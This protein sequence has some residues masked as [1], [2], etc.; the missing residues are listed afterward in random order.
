MR[1]AWVSLSEVAERTEGQ[2]M[3]GNSGLPTGFDQESLQ[4]NTKPLQKA[5]IRWGGYET[6]L[7][8]SFA[9]D[10]DE[11]SVGYAGADGQGTAYAAGAAVKRA[12]TS[13][14]LGET[15]SLKDYYNIRNGQLTVQ[16]NINALN[17]RIEPADQYSPRVR[18]RQI[19]GIVR[20]QCVRGVWENSILTHLRAC[21]PEMRALFVAANLFYL[22]FGVRKALQGDYSTIVEM[23]T[24]TSAVMVGV[25]G[26]HAREAGASFKYDMVNDPIFP[27][28]R[29]TRGAIGTG[30]LAASR[31]V[32][33][34][35]AKS[36]N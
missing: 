6:L 31:L 4:L 33:A 24:F 26:L 30:I 32:R 27:G 18:A 36:S 10:A 5:V 34:T 3:V 35:P 23:A 12:E 25:R 15:D 22:G 13:R 8:A 7:L 28:I 16:W 9:G 29:L 11:V 19:D 1:G 2:I 17:S 14:H 20:D 21:P